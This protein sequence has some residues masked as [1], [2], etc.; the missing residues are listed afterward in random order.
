MYRTDQVFN[1]I[2]VVTDAGSF[3]L[4]SLELPPRSDTYLG[5]FSG[6]EFCSG[7]AF[8]LFGSK[9]GIKVTDMSRGDQGA[10]VHSYI[11]HS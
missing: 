2:S 5:D 10:S 1:Q 9:Q 4:L 7:S 8:D 6:S 3:F 11:Q